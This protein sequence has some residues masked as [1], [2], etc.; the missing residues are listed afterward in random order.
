MLNWWEGKRGERNIIDN[1]ESVAHCWQVA[2]E[3]SW[4]YQVLLIAWLESV[5]WKA[6]Q[7]CCSIC[8][9]S[10]A[11]IVF[12]PLP[13]STF[14]LKNYF[15]FSQDGEA[16][17]SG[18]NPCCTLYREVPALLSKSPFSRRGLASPYGTCPCSSMVTLLL[19]LLSSPGVDDVDFVPW[20]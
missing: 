17:G 6:V 7:L 16:E 19:L 12:S 18:N 11:R 8:S 13:L 20:L 10:Q 3:E 15:F 1:I 2:D 14:V 9:A 5:A 4:V